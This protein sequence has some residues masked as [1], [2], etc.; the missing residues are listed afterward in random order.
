[1]H[2]YLI[3]NKWWFILCITFQSIRIILEIS[4]ALFLNAVIDAAGAKDR[5][6]LQLLIF[7]GLIF[8]V[9]FSIVYYIGS[10]CRA[11]FLEKTIRDLKSDLFSSLLKED[12]TT[13]T[14]RNSAS[15]ISILNNDVKMVEDN[16]FDSTF[17]IIQCILKII[18]ASAVLIFVNPIVAVIAIALSFIPMIIPANSGKKLAA[19]KSSYSKNLEKYNEKIKDIFTGFEVIKSFNIEK[20]IK[21]NHDSVNKETEHKKY[22]SYKANG[23]INAFSNLFSIGIQFTIFIISGFFVLSGSLTVGNIV[24]ITQLSGTILMPVFNLINEINNKK[25][26]KGINKK[27]LLMMTVESKNS[28]GESID[29]FNQYIEVK[30]LSYTYDGKNKVLD[31][32]NFKINKNKKYAIVGASGSGKSTLLKLLLRYYDD[33]NGNILVDGLDNRKIKPESLYKICSV[34]HQNV[35]MFEDT[36]RNNIALYNN[37]PDEKVQECLDKSGLHDLILKIDGG[38]NA[39]IK[40]SG[41]NFSGG[42][43]QRIAIARSLIKGTK[44]LILDEATSNLDNETA[45]NI[46]RSLLNIPDLTCLVVTHRYN[47]ELLKLYDKIL[48][49]KNGKL[50]EKGNFDELMQRKDYFYSLYNV[51]N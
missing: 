31:N 49:L 43:K 14:E 22:E 1:M 20:N 41:H 38:M 37:Y 23:V 42:E 44:L 48:V 33:Y 10:I 26:I 6:E 16:Y 9:I 28:T 13:F 19:L 32:I 11:K 27:L 50:Y 51:A 18:C 46:E 5:H 2:K 30:N 12:I 34:I 7:I 4:I 15:Y 45:Y 17:K 39:V 35:F 24:A 36:I 29:N 8:A 3:K 40:E 25:S 21:M 47:H